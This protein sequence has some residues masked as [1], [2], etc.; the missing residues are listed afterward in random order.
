[1]NK[2]N[3]VDSSPFS[4]SAIL[5]PLTPENNYT[6][7]IMICGGSQVADDL[8][9]TS[10]SVFTPTSAQCSRLVLTT[11]GIAAGWK[12]EFMPTPRIMVELIQLPDMRILMV[13]GAH[14]G[15]AGYGFVSSFFF[16]WI[17][18]RGTWIFFLR[19]FQAF[20]KVGNSSATNP[21]FLPVLYDPFA[22]EGNRFSSAGIPAST[23]ARMYHSTAS[24]TPNGTVM[25]GKN[26]FFEIIENIYIRSWFF[27]W[28]K[29]QWWCEDSE[30]CYR[31]PVRLGALLFFETNLSLFALDLNF[32]RRLICLI[33]A[34][35]T[36]GFQIPLT[37]TKNLSWRLIC[38][39]GLLLSAV[40]RPI[41]FNDK[42]RG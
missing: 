30:V 9:P 7:E 42:D 15:T 5:L 6:P 34:Q 31:I 3:R 24:L 4:A 28:I 40:S 32:F 2:L 16:V 38:P 36:Q 17:L 35:R 20:D 12:V 22:P 18:Q 21:A 29:S 10:Y 8:P 33:L 13:N 25:V 37:T 19:I 27:S 26:L 41:H 23:I 11:A 14:T 39:Q 1:M